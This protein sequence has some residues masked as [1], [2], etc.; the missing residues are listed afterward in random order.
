MERAAPYLVRLAATELCSQPIQTTLATPY[1]KQPNNKAAVMIAT[2]Y[3]K[4][5]KLK[6]VN[7]L[8]GASHGGCRV[9]RK[10]VHKRGEMLDVQHCEHLRRPVLSILDYFNSLQKLFEEML[11]VH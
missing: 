1:S 8:I 11:E 5:R 7:T 10:A 3:K 4:K 6:F 2:R 9:W